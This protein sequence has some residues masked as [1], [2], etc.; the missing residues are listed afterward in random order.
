MAPADFIGDAANTAR[1]LQALVKAAQAQDHAPIKV[2][3]NGEPGIG[4]SALVK[5][6]ILLLGTS[7]HSVSKFNGT[8]MKLEVVE[9]IADRLHY[10]D[11]YSDYQMIQIE[12]ADLIPRVAQNR[13]LTVL[14]DLPRGAAV[15]C[16]SNCTLEEPPATHEVE[17]LLRRWPLR[18]LDI[19]NIAVF[20]AGNVRAAL[21]D[22][23]AALQ[24]TPES[25]Q[26][27]A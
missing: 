2:L 1:L 22:A 11:L 12:E 18:E 3:L 9:E 17:S 20:S 15:V 19:K 26:S 24:G 27:A 8:Q 25:L 7:K 6:L 14:D 4:K 16:T 5:Y 13:F 10:R 23:E 21:L